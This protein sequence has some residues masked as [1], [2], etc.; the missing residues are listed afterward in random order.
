[1]DRRSFILK[2]LLFCGS[3]LIPISKDG[4]CLGTKQLRGIDDFKLRPVSNTPDLLI[5]K[6]P[7]IKSGFKQLDKVLGG[8]FHNSDFILIA[9]RPL[10]GRTAFAI[11]ILRNRLPTKSSNGIPAGFLTN[12]ICSLDILYKVAGVPEKEVWRKIHTRSDYQKL[13]SKCLKLI[14]PPV[15]INN[16]F[17]HSIH[18]V[19]SMARKMVRN[20]N[21]KIIF[22]EGLNGIESSIKIISKQIKQLAVELDV[23]IIATATVNRLPSPR[24]NGRPIIS[25][26][27]SF[28]HIE[29]NADV[30]LFIH[31]QLASEWEEAEI[32]I[33]KNRNGVTD[34]IRLSCSLQPL[35]FEDY[36]SKNNLKE[37][38]R[39]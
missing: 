20:E 15:Y 2:S 9:S 18:Q 26:I 29:P 37:N 3:G 13:I 33:A 25:D 12:H 23:P 16:T 11:S 36:K 21:V 10:M 34:K 7:F 1:M 24:Q 30:I 6:P 39:T 4:F 27:D 28:E 5:T 31:R 32:L 8:G 19:K 38:Y 17:A 35:L 22:I 14:S